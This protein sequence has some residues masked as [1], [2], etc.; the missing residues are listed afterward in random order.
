MEHWWNDTD[1]GKKPGPV[2]LSPPQILYGLASGDY[3]PEAW[4]GP[5]LQVTVQIVTHFCYI[6]IFATEVSVQTT[7]KFRHVLCVVPSADDV[8][9]LQR[10]YLSRHLHLPV[11]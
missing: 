6:S 1:R 3:P 11:V 10:L 5:L 8:S 7:Y 9:S 2:P 4:H